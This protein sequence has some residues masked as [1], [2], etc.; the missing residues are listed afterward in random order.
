MIVQS[1]NAESVVDR[2]GHR[3][4][5]L[6]LEKNGVAHDHPARFRFLECRPGAQSH[7]RRH[8]PSIDNNFHVITREGDF[9]NAFLF[10]QL[11]FESSEIVDLCSIQGCE[12]ANGRHGKNRRQD[13]K[14]LHW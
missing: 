13:K 7:E 4:I 1:R 2:G 3:R 12:S 6:I 9:V 14:L 11:P 5:H 8:S 10:V